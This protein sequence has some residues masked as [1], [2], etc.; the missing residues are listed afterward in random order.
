[1][2][3]GGRKKQDQDGTGLIQKKF[4]YFVCVAF[5]DNHN[6]IRYFIFSKEDVEKFPN[7]VWKNTPELK[8]ITLNRDGKELDQ[9]IKDSENKWDKII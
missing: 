8:N 7:V 9:I 6:N 2:I 3:I 1:M 4:D 5:D